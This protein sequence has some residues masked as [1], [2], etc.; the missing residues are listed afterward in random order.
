LL[1]R[2]RL[3]APIFLAAL[4]GVERFM[5]CKPA[6]FSP[7]WR[8]RVPHHTTLYAFSFW[9]SSYRLMATVWRISPSQLV[10]FFLSGLRSCKDCTSLP[11]YDE[12]RLGL[13]SGI[14]LV[15][16]AC[17]ICSTPVSVSFPNKAGNSRKIQRT[18]PARSGFGHSPG[19]VIGTAT[20][21]R[22]CWPKIEGYDYVCKSLFSFS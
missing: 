9:L 4:H 5:F 1:D 13:S 7:L 22:F 8:R 19:S 21:I 11:Y 12:R 17:F 18:I 15:V 6:V 3:V 14:A 20:S 16:N 2:A 10:G